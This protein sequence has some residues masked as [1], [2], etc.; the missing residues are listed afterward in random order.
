MIQNGSFSQLFNLLSENRAHIRQYKL[1]YIYVRLCI[2]GLTHIC[3]DVH[4]CTSICT[5]FLLLFIT[6]VV[7]QFVL[8]LIF[9]TF[10]PKK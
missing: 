6:I 5:E 2:Y 9:A 8:L 7:L 4:K 1:T 3:I 10:R